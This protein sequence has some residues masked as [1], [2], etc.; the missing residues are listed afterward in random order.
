ML[1]ESFEARSEP[2]YRDTILCYKTHGVPLAL[3]ALL[4]FDSRG[5][6]WIDLAAPEPF[7]VPVIVL[8]TSILEA[9]LF[10][11]ISV[12]SLDN[13]GGKYVHCR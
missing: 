3:L 5:S 13:G 6:I 1:L 12:Y 2:T 11:F 9:F 8:D 7:H 4:A 10:Q